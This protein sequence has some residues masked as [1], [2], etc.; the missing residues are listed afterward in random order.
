MF[1]DSAVQDLSGR[2]ARELEGFL[3]QPNRGRALDERRHLDLAASLAHLAEATDGIMPGLSGRLADV[4]VSIEQGWRVRALG[5]RSYFQLVRTLINGDEGAAEA[6]LSRIES[7]AGRPEERS[8]VHFG[9]PE[10]DQLSLD[11]IDD[12]M[13]LAPISDA[14]AERFARLLD[15]GFDLMAQTL[16]ALRAEIAGLVPEVL[17]ARAP[18][19]DAMEFDGASHYQFWGLLLLNPLHHRD[20]LAVVE[21]LTHESSHAL[22][23]GLTTNEPLVLNPDEELYPSPLR[24][25]PRPMDGIYHAAYVSARMCWAMEQLASSSLLSSSD[26]RR[27]TDAARKDRA[28]WERGL[29]EIDAHGRLS[30]TG[31]RVLDAAREV[32]SGG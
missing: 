5:F 27:A 15:E 32:M 28:N 12:G 19:G 20:P 11:L 4:A 2:T 13:R 26:R 14:E 18:A 7:M 10:A 29:A 24:L 22:L 16:P 6:W 21:V 31:A 17:L 23:F 30:P 3:P 1:L 25:D 9:A 8:V